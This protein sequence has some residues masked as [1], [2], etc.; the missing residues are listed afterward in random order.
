[1]SATGKDRI[2]R[3]DR[4]RLEVR[5]LAWGDWIVK[6]VSGISYPSS[7]T[8]YRLMRE[9]LNHGGRSGPK[10]TRATTAR[11]PAYRPHP[12]ES[13]THIAVMDLPDSIRVVV[14]AR[15]AHL[16]NATA[17]AEILGITARQ[18]YSRL[19]IARSLLRGLVVDA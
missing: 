5:L 4:D 6:P 15:Y 12:R 8:E 11:I 13:Q 14:V 1:M 3:R 9:A 2:R 7:T 18:V 10:S 16:L 19:D 17:V